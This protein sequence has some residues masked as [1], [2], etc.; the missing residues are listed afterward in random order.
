V[1]SVAPY[2]VLWHLLMGESEGYMAALLHESFHA[3]QGGA[4]EARLAQA[5]NVMALE[6]SYPYDAAR[7]EWQAELNTLADA[8]LAGTEAEAH[9]LAQRFLAERAER[10]ATMGLSDELINFERQ[11]EW[12]EGL[13]KYAELSIGRAAA[14]ADGYTPLPLLADDPD[15]NHY[16]N[17][18]RYWTQQFG[19]LRRALNHE[20]EIRYYYTGMAQAVLL[21]RLL[22]NW[23]E[24]AFEDDVWL[25]DLL[26]AA[27]AS[28]DG[29]G[30]RRDAR[31]M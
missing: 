2:R 27:V 28:A 9:T 8:A 29:V 23:K 13:A 11:R 10:R 15:F 1:R 31:R 14:T 7:A 18:D 6:A 12:L 24:R 26:L 16:A 20:G 21:D 22:P 5:E 17:R 30:E 25:E 19:E 4:A 3:F